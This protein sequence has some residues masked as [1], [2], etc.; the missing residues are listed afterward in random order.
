MK[1]KGRNVVGPNL[2]T[3][4]LHIVHGSTTCRQKISR[5]MLKQGLITSIYI[6]HW[7]KNALVQHNK[8]EIKKKNYSKKTKH[9]LVNC[10]FSLNHLINAYEDQFKYEFC[11]TPSSTSTIIPSISGQKVLCHLQEPNHQVVQIN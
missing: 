5:K 8:R 3:K 6:I 10:C 4:A 11:M 2:Q 7:E 1:Q 9:I